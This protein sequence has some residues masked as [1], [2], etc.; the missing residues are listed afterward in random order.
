MKKAAYIT[1]ISILLLVLAGGAWLVDA[2]RH[3]N[4]RHSSDIT[5]ERTG[6]GEPSATSS[7]ARR[8]RP[9]ASADTDLHPR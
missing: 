2:L 1:L 9:P 5:L 6:T 3:P 8:S 4:P 7:A